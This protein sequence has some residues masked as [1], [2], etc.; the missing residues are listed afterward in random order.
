MDLTQINLQ[1]HGIQ[2]QLD[3]L[4]KEIQRMVIEVKEPIDSEPTE[5]TDTG[6]EPIAP[7]YENMSH[8]EL[9]DYCNLN[10]IRGISKKNKQQ[11]IDK[12]KIHMFM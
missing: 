1:M 12:I 10:N 8:K 3:E 4:N 11:L 7:V 2:L 9:K 6:T 5:P